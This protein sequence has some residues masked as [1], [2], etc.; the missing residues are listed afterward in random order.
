M[1][2]PGSLSDVQVDRKRRS[3]ELALCLRV[4]PFSEPVSQRQCLDRALVDVEL[5]K[6]EHAELFDHSDPGF[7]LRRRLRFRLRMIHNSCVS[8]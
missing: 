7:R 2:S 1:A 5:A 3:P 6:S 4:G 8:V